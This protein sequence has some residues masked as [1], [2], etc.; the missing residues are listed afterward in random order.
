MV[1]YIIKELEEWNIVGGEIK[2][3]VSVVVNDIS[4]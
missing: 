1:V 2:V 3:I 4:V